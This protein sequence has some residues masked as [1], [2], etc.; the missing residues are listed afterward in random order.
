M[1]GSRPL[2]SVG[3]RLPARARIL[4]A[5]YSLPNNAISQAWGLW[6]IYFYAPPEGSD[7]VTRVPEWLG[8]EPRLAL[9]VLLTASR[10]IESVDDPL[11]GYWTDRTRSRW[12]R[13]IPFVVLGTPVWGVLFALLFLPPGAGSDAVNL[14]F[15]FV[16]ASAFYLLSNLSG[17]PMEALLPAIARRKDDRL[18]VATWQVVFGVLGAVVG[19]SISS[20]LQDRYGFAAMAITIAAVAVAA[21]FVALAGC[22]EQAKRDDQASSAGLGESVRAV[23]SNAQ[24][25][26]Y[27]PSF[28]LFQVALQL[29]VAV[30]PFYVDTVFLDGSLL[31]WTARDDSGVFTFLLTAAVIAGMLAAIAPFRRYAARY[32][33]ARAF[34]AA[35][36]GA[37]CYYPLLFFAGALPAV[38]VGVQA[39]VAILLA[40]LPTAGVYLFPAIITADIADED[41]RSTGHRREAMFYGT[42]NAL[43]KFATALAPLLFALV[44]LAG[45]SVEDPLGI[46]LVG[47]VAGLLTLLAFISFRRYSLAEQADEAL[48]VPGSGGRARTNR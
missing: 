17:A 18:S 40:G 43:E 34:R 2:A 21:R 28:V 15:V 16:V 12:G 35:L 48:A 3:A 24:F 13:R 29:L 31:S 4:Y 22:W 20:L 6:L 44:L 10:L 45:D 23:L 37:A 7:A 11:V 39:V 41:T 42:Q 46:R 9:G 1:S 25:L 32:D 14:L 26:Y 8:L 27:L 33:K 47:P 5:A 36:I 38:P 19:L 30:L